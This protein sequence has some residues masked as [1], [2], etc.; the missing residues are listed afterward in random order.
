MV[1]RS[2]PDY[3]VVPDVS[4]RAQHRPRGTREITVGERDAVGGWGI[5]RGVV[6]GAGGYTSDTSR[7]VF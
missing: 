1:S 4:R 5:V 6:A 2:N 3:T 7:G